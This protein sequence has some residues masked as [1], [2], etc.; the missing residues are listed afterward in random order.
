MSDRSDES[1]LVNEF[2]QLVHA[3]FYRLSYKDMRYVKTELVP[4]IQPRLTESRSRGALDTGR[5]RHVCL[6]ARD[7]S[8]SGPRSSDRSELR[9]RK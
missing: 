9:E 8:R 2:M 7:N 4:T 3:G 5:H 6:A 1:I